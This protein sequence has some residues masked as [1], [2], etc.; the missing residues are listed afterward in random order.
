MVNHILEIAKRIRAAGNSVV[1]LSQTAH[2]STKGVP[3]QKIRFSGSRIPFFRNV[4]F[5]FRS[6][7]H[8]R[9]FDL[10]HSQYHPAIFAGNVASGF[11]KKPHVFTYH[12]FAPVRAWRSPRQRL[13]MIDHRIG[14]FVALRS[15]TDKII[16]VSH[17]LKDELIRSYFVP[18]KEIKVIYNGVDLDRFHPRLDG[19]RIR[20]LYQVDCRD[21]VVLYLGRLAPYKGVQFLI[22]AAPQILKELPKT[23]FIISGAARYDALNLMTMANRLH[24][25]KSV[26]FTGYVPDENIPHLYAACDVFCYPSLWEGFGL[27]PVEAQACGKPIVGFHTCSMPEVVRNGQTGLLVR[28]KN[29]QALA[30]AIL[31]ILHDDRKRNKMGINGR[32]RVSR[33]FSWD[34]AAERTLEVYREAMQ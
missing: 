13:K 16:T 22:E 1:I 11:L 23:R 10:V 18:N 20:K 28:T 33:M 4:I 8:L 24:V 3:V 32:Y 15:M 30:D 7:Q 14:T 29:S 19:Q 9:N 25:R 34:E 21:P 31:S 2:V 17:Y 12:G 27:P 6:L 5:P 26:I